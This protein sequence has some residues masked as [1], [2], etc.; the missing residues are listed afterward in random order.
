[1][2]VDGQCD[3]GRVCSHFKRE[4]RFRNQFAG[5]RADDPRTNQATC[6]LVEKEFCHA[7]V[8]GYGACAAAGCPGKAGFVNFDALRLGLCFGQAHPGNLWIGV[9]DRRN[10]TRVEPGLVSGNDFGRYLAL[11]ARLVRQH[12]LANDVS[13]CE[14][15]WHIGAQLLVH[16]NETVIVDAHAGGLRCNRLAIRTPTDC[17]QHAI[18]QLG[19]GGVVAFEC[20]FQAILLHL[21]L[22]DF[23]LEVNSLVAFLDAFLQRP[24]QVA[25]SAGDQPIEQLH[26]RDFCAERVVDTRHLQADDA[27]AYYEQPLWDIRQCQCRGGIHQPGIVIRKS[28]NPGR[29]GTRCNDGMVEREPL[30]AFSRCNVHHIR[31]RKS[32]RTLHDGY[33]ALFRET[34]EAA[35]GFFHYRGFP[36]AQ[37]VQFYLWLAEREAEVT[38]LLRF[39]SH[40]GRMQQSLRWDAADIEAHTAQHRIAFHQYGL[41]AEISRPERGRVTARARTQYSDLRMNVAL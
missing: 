10:G 25:I 4:H 32:T 38:H 2:G 26:Y 40:A 29:L 36:F 16:R 17:K 22:R 13:D 33:F 27:A 39:G 20:G 8:T 5:I 6:G 3:I 41:Q 9:G 18:V 35:N 21:E 7:F 14:D 19:C 23:G 24:D 37:S 11:V 34:R 30:Y 15:V 28:W 31:R 12:G 1:M